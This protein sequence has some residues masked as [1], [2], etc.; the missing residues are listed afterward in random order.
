MKKCGAVFIAAMCAAIAFL[1]CSS[2]GGTDA[3]GA[4]E[5]AAFKPGSY[6]ASA[7]GMDGNVT[8]SVTFS[9]DAITDISV[10]DDNETAGVGDLA[11]AIVA[12]DIL[13]RQSLDVDTV[14][15][16]TISSFAMISAVTDAVNQAGG[17]AALKAAPEAASAVD[18]TYDYD[19]V[20]VGAGIAG[21]NA[22]LAAE[23][24]G[25]SV[26]L[27]EKTGIVGGTSIFSSGTFLAATTE[28]GT[29]AMAE[30][31][32]SRNK[33]HERNDVDEG[34]VS[35]LAE[36]SPEA[37]GLIE[38]T[39]VEFTV[40]DMV[41]H[42]A[43]S[44]RAVKNAS[45]IHM[46][47]AEPREKGGE[48]LITALK[49]KLERDGVKIY[50]NTPATS[51]L[52]DSAGKV[53]G[54]VSETEGGKLTFNAKA[55]ILATG[56]YSRNSEMTAALCPRAAGNYTASSVGN[57]GDG[58]RMALD[59]GAVLDDFQ[60]SMSGVFAPNPYDMPVVGQPN[61]SYPYDC[62]LVNAAGERVISETAGPH[63]QM[64]YFVVEGGADYGW[65]I[66]DGEIA[67]RFLNLDEYLDATAN[68]SPF[69]EAY[70]ADSIEALAGMMG[71][72]AAALQATV[73]R[74]NEMCAAGED[75]DFG[76][77]AEYLS[78]VDDG[79]YF[80]VKEYNMTRG[81]YGGIL[82]NENAEVIDAEGNAIGGLYAAGII[83]SGAFFGDYYPGMEALGVGTYMGYIAGRNAAE[84]AAAK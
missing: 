8:V 40:S 42:P 41:F 66:M 9:A 68:R 73:D 81:N 32:I 60:E 78:A 46:A 67:D 74:Y 21:L 25:V 47:D 84:S 34:M 58:I 71:V 35:A 17:A 22:S 55:V 51:L 16:A 80:A 14:S 69:I 79:T 54:V 70:R 26:A 7:R 52:T 49:D 27:L 4:G 76:K 45:T 38:T 36:A 65:V 59:A 31:W 39:G 13:A 82:T 48:S 44:E 5:A 50:L 30:A 62:L 3:R 18:E 72:D 77:S 83:S 1:G 15:G 2:A 53:T 28:D 23:T 11:L 64:I 12:E 24:A 75:A 61:N 6:T 10:V 56:D 19:V 29:D 20:V 43:P 63:D 37:I 57:T 33:I